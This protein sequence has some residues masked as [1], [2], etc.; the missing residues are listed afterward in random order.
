VLRPEQVPAGPAAPEAGEL[1]E[2]VAALRPALVANAERLAEA[3]R[4]LQDTRET[5]ATGR[6]RRQLLHESAF[7][8]LQAQLATMP[9]IEQAKG[10]LIAQ[11]GCTPDAAF[12]MLR[13]ASQRSNVRVSDL[14][15]SIVQRAT[16]AGPRPGPGRRG[17]PR[18]AS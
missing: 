18:A 12:G 4:Q 13:Q 17:R 2:R 8:R 15:T 5:L 14:A 6:T 1:S 9:V 11:T 16:A 3:R 10:I 7:A